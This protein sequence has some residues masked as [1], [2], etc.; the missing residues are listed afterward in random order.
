[1]Y[2][3]ASNS[4]ISGSFQGNTFTGYYNNNDSEDPMQDQI[5]LLFSDDFNMI[6]SVNWTK[7]Y[8]SSF[9]G[10]ESEELKFTGK[11]IPLDANLHPYYFDVGYRV[12]GEATCSSITKLTHVWVGDESPN[13][14][15]HNLDYFICD[16]NSMI[17]IRLDKE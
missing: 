8:K 10:V 4:R 17:Q 5:E 13:N 7:L 15:T 14:Y 16:E 11:N 12:L 3:E 1:M 2:G 9:W 6:L